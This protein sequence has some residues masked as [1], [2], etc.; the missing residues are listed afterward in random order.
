MA[1]RLLR[2]V[3]VSTVGAAL[4]CFAVVQAQT[5]GEKPQ[6]PKETPQVTKPVAEDAE[7]AQ[8]EK[9]DH[10]RKFI[11]RVEMDGDNIEVE[12][13]ADGKHLE[14][15]F[16]TREFVERLFA[17]GERGERR[18]RRF[19][20]GMEERR[21]SFEHPERGM[22]SFRKHIHELR[23]QLEEGG[24]NSEGLR[25]SIEKHAGSMREHAE[26]YQE[27][28]GRHGEEGPQ[29]MQRFL[30]KRVGELRER[31]ERAVP[32]SERLEEM[33]RALRK[34][35]EERFGFQD[36]DD[37]RGNDRYQGHGRDDD[38]GEDHGNNRGND[39]YQGHGRDDDRG[40]D[41]GNNRGNDRYQGHGRDDD[42]GDRYQRR[43][44]ILERVRRLLQGLRNERRTQRD[45]QNRYSDYGRRDGGD[46]SSRF[47]RG[48]RDEG[49]HGG[50]DQ[51]R[52]DGGDFRPQR[53]WD[54]HP[55]G[56]HPY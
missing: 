22:E 48:D 55:E 41:H 2:Y 26:R 38:R 27:E 9:D 15:T 33:P 29:R 11:V 3:G 51:P 46:H 36:R 23:K 16:N 40:E 34:Q 6:Q 37:D 56:S 31:V 17:G 49:R 30:K 35:L 44:G 53:E 12:V 4:C 18:I 52:F 47:R 24:E 20:E 13:E 45:R 25:R 1:N 43:G 19:V 28:F 5:D 7:G 21:D 42:R 54:R 14:R 50:Y 8:A 39:R 10:K 32:R